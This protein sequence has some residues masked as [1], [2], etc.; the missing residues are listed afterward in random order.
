MLLAEAGRLARAEYKPSYI[1]AFS[2]QHCPN[3]S[4]YGYK[5][6]AIQE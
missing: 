6:G 1:K 5:R 2:N 4:G 3:I